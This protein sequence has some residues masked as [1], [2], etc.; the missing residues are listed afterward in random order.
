M[1]GLDF[2]RLARGSASNTATEP[3]RIF[4][5][6]PDKDPKYT[7]PRDVQTEVWE[8]WHARRTDQDIV[9]KM[10][11]GGGKTVVGLLML[12]SCLNEMAGPA[13][14]LTPDNFLAD[15]VRAE[16][17]ALGIET[18]DDPGSGRFRSGKAILV[19]NV[20]RLING[21]SVF[22]IAGSTRPIIEV[23]AILVDDA[24]ACLATVDSQFTLTIPRAHPTYDQ[25]LD[26]F[27]DDLRRQSAPGLRDLLAA[28]PSV[29]LP[30]PYW[31]WADRRDRVLEILHPHRT[32]EKFR[33]SWPLLADCLHICNAAISAAAIEI[34]PPC[35]P[36]HQ[37]PSFA[38]AGRRIY[39]TATLAD[40]GVLV[41]HFGA[42]PDSLN[43]PI[44]PK[45]ADDLG[46]RM[47]FTPLETFPG[48]NESAIR[49]YLK[50]QSSR[51]N[52]VVIVPSWRV[53]EQWNDVADAIYDKDTIQE[54]VKS[55]RNGHVG[56]ALII[57]KYDGIDLPYDACRILV[58]D[59]LPEAYGAL[60]RLEYRT[61]DDS[62]AMVTRQ[63]Q[64]IEQGMGRGV[65]ANDDYC[66]VVLLGSR[67]TQRI[68]TA[69][70]LAKFSPATRAQLELS[71]GVAEMLH[72]KPFSSMAAVAD[73]CLNRDRD[74]IIA[75]R[76]VLDGIA[77]P[78][79]D[80]ITPQAI[81]QRKAFQAAELG[82]PREAAQILQAVA[83]TTT[84]LKQRGWLKQQ[85]A[86]YL[87]LADPATA[88]SRQVSAQADN[89][90]L[91]KPRDG[92][93]YIRLRTSTEQGQHLADELSR[94][95]ANAV[96][97]QVGF[98]AIL[99]DLV[100][101]TDAT[102]VN[103]FEQ[104]MF[105]LGLH[106]GFLAQRP[107]RDL[108]EGPDVLW[109]LGGLNFLVIECKSGVETNFI[110]KSDAAQ[111]SHAIDWF[112]HKY[113][114][115]CS[116]IPVMVHKTNVLHSTATARQGTRVITFDKLAA[117]RD[118]VRTF[119][120]AIAA[121]GALHDPARLTAQLNA[122]GLNGPAFAPRWSAITRA[123]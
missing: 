23:G 57:N 3:R 53:A 9:I 77:Y 15:Q 2:T 75:S 87:H 51:H 25:L 29:A 93:E 59:G 49:T 99:D 116:P 40:D 76:D 78:S 19:T 38:N 1:T 61:L 121:D 84:D 17:Q 88:Q 122:H 45:T 94:R 68:R 92:I 73:Q 35:P 6:L 90:A 27:K 65:R 66:V 54:G 107:E 74:W 81:A 97:M 30:V 85:S 21:M 118:A 101:H 5:A 119:A 103:R 7:Y 14:Y 48:T 20:Y 58:L 106:L 47:I 114:P 16:A 41:T 82:R 18:T 79:G 52:V 95:Y 105:D 70:G 102:S 39:L 26:L 12:K 33:F 91:L 109:L 34:Q 31:A 120:S 86:A 42:G 36:I 69:S 13:V 83:D 50:E 98:A 60:D 123:S 56:L 10:N 113:D 100:P 110:A 115:T 55:L 104:A 8:Q 71:D 46:D 11:T 72:G 67:L 22:G 44:T 37:I 4:T 117:L 80:R 62:D 112:I 43:R 63:I 64:R 96:A 28:D 108:G 32:D 89:R 24:H 111:L